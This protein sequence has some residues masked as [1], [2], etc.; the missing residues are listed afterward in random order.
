MAL[1]C[2]RVSLT[3]VSYNIRGKV[4]SI[5]QVADTHVI[6]PMKLKTQKLHRELR[7]ELIKLAEMEGTRAIFRCGNYEIMRT[8]SDV[9]S[10]IKPEFEGE[11]QRMLKAMVQNGWMEM[12]PNLSSGKL[13]KTAGQ[14]W[15]NDM[16]V[17]SHRLKPEWLEER[18]CHLGEDGFPDIT[19]LKVFKAGDI[20]PDAEHT[21][22]AANGETK[23]LAV[24]K[25]MAISGELSRKDFK[26]LQEEPWFELEVSSFQGIEGLQTYADLMLTPKQQKIAKGI[27]PQLTTQRMNNKRI[28][29]SILRYEKTKLLNAPRR[30]EVIAEMAQMRRDGYSL[31]QISSK[32]LPV[33]VGKNKKTANKI[34]AGLGQSLKKQA[35]EKQK[36]AKKKAGKDGAAPPKVMLFQFRSESYQGKGL[37]YES[38]KGYSFPMGPIITRS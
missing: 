8:L 31:E 17:G 28:A 27:D 3:T 23:N 4:T 29:R 22:L 9:I 20:L 7:K 37:H 30:K 19:K 18:F 36:Q 24:W 33:S 26:E 2:I 21:C 35:L 12:R 38:Q 13:E 6:R 11:D 25:E 34:R 5:Q 16:Q 14:P 32:V 10:E 15:K 1:G